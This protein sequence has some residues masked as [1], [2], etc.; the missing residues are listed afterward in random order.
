MIAGRLTACAVLTVAVLAQ[1]TAL[2]FIRPLRA[3]D[4]LPHDPDDPA[5]WVNR[6]DPARSLIF[7]TVKVAAPNGALAVFDLHGRL[8]QM[9]TGPD[10]PNNV[11]VAYGLSL[12]G[13]PT[14][15]V[16]LTERLGRRLRVYAIASDGTG[17]RDIS[18]TSLKILDG[19]PG[20]QG[21]PMGIGLY[22]RP[23]DGAIFAIVAPK[24]GPRDGYLWQYRV[25]DDGTGHV[26]TT[27]VRRVGGE[28]EAVAVD[29]AL[30]YV[31]Y[32]DEQTG[33]H[34]W[35]ADPDDPAA[36]RELAV[37]ASTGYRG[38]REGIGIYA[39]PDGTGFIICVD[40]TPGDSTFHVYRRE[41]E[42][43]RP[44]D[45]SREVVAFRVGAD[46]TDGLEVTSAP[47]GPDFPRGV[48]VA[49]NSSSRNFLLVRWADIE[50][51]V[52]SRPGSSIQ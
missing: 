24:A 11:D 41:G 5:I 10:R 33:L 32:A 35:H 47:I 20:E 8:R 50:A 23:R 43:G 27:F 28:I 29:S 19:A 21:A 26:K 44:H 12:G 22:R 46:S 15:I 25:S 13:V 1:S 31:Y 34:K 14:D 9:L 6:L 51:L 3:T 16:V 52:G 42:P 7:G 40:Q 4:V 36:G 30:G 18:G 38:D 48:L 45:H 2:P 49:M 37:F 39:R 17:A